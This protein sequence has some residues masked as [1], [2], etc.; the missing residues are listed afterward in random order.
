MPVEKV[1][2]G[3]KWGNH[4]KVYRGKGARRKAANHGYAAMRN[5]YKEPGMSSEEAARRLYGGK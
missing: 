2:G 4:G 5:G 1:D 3:F